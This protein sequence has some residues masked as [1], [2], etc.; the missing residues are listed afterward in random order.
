MLDIKFIREHADL[1]KQGARDKRNPIDIDALLRLDSEVR[2]LQTQWEELQ[3]SRNRLSKEI[4]KAAPQERDSMKAE[5]QAIKSNMEV[6]E[7]KL[8]QKKSE[9]DAMLLLVPQ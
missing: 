2:P 9:L 8:A 1:V 7:A 3:S 5:V 4:G 6:I